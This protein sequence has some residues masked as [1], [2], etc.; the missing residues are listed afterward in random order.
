M[1]EYVSIETAGIVWVKK[2]RK[3]WAKLQPLEFPSV[4]HS[5]YGASAPSG[6]LAAESSGEQS[7]EFQSLARS[8]LYTRE[9]L[10][11]KYCKSCSK[12]KSMTKNKSTTH[13]A[14]A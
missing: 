11:R 13:S 5:G 1:V 6:A 9:K 3:V 8:T 10:D 14:E 12:S 7:C 4:N 2:E